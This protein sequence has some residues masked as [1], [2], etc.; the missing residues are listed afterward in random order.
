MAEDAAA[1]GLGR[2]RRDPAPET[3]P[4]PS[5]GNPDETRAGARRAARVPDDGPGPGGLTRFG[6]GVPTEEPASPA[7]GAASVGR[8]RRRSRPWLG[9]LLTLI[10]VVAFLAWLLTR[11]ATPLAIGGVE[12][13]ANP[14]RASCGAIV[15]VVG[16]VTTG[17]EGG[18]FRYQ[19][20]RSDGQTSDVL[21][22]TVPRDTT[23]SQVHL[24]W[25]VSGQGRFDGRATLRVLD[26]TPAEGSGTFVYACS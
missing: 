15:D 26:P 20:T 5:S 22:Q 25:A 18:T 8:R 9:G 7:W 1:T 23:T 13:A 10:V 16:T 6:P 4:P 3:A 17:A 2:R 11:Q 12:V 19:W 21:T 14:A 24:Q